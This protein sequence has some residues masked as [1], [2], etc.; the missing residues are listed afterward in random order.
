[1]ISTISVKLD[2]DYIL[3]PNGQMTLS[4]QMGT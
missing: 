2:V 3:T 1:M 4:A